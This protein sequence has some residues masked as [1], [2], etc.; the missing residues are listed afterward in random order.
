MKT[1]VLSAAALILSGSIFA[2]DKLRSTEKKEVKSVQKEVRMEEENGAS[3]KEL[4]LNE[5]GVR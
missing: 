3:L 5:K 4:Q 1:L 2:Q